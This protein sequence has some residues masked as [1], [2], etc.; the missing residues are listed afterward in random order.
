MLQP[1]SLAKSCTPEWGICPELSTANATFRCIA[2]AGAF[3]KCPDMLGKRVGERIKAERKSRG[4]SQTELANRCRPKT[5]YQQIDKLESGERRLTLDWL[6]RIAAALGVE[7]AVLLGAQPA[8]PMFLSQPV[9]NEIAQTLAE[10]AL[11]GQVPEPGIVEALALILQELTATFSAHPQA[12]RDPEV[13]RPVVSLASR[14]H[15][16]ATN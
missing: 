2:N 15:A 12:Y 6:E 5:V 10:V 11:E 7:P 1:D 14:R 13:A 8:Q 9:A 3:A 4:W 16:P